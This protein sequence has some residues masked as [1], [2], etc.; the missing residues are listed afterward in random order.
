[1]ANDIL[2][3]IEFLENE[4]ELEKINPE[5]LYLKPKIEKIKEEHRSDIVKKIYSTLI[6]YENSERYS[7]IAEHKECM[8]TKIKRFQ[9]ELQEIL[10]KYKEEEK[11]KEMKNKDSQNNINSNITSTKYSFI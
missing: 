11:Q 9:N 8:K 2:R 1:M 3:N 10:E 6:E 7:K 5:I 4:N